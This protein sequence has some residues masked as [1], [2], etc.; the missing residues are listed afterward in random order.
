MGGGLHHWR[1]GGE[2]GRAIGLKVELG[3]RGRGKLHF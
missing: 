1:A 2:L 3:V